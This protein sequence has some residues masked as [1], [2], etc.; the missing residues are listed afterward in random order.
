MQLSAAMTA[1]TLT[2]LDVKMPKTL[3]DAL[4]RTERIITEARTLGVHRD[5]LVPAVIAALSAGKE[6]AVDPEVQR[7]IAAQALGDI[8]PAVQQEMEAELRGFLSQHADE[9]TSCFVA[10]FSAAVTI[11]EVACERL[12]GLALDDS[13]NILALGGDVADVWH[14]ARNAFA[15]VD[16]LTG[17]WRQLG[18]V[19]NQPLNPNHPNGHLAPLTLAQWREHA[20]DNVWQ[21]IQAGIKPDLAP[22][23]TEYARRVRAIAAELASQQQAGLD[24]A[25]GKRDLTT[26]RS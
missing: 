18:M 13:Q 15:Q 3:T 4:T 22:T 8:G 25:L 7:V 2:A 6:P 17:A 9:I 12:G 19:T 1:R 5:A 24:R 21:L 26:L 16:R 10:P 23:Y 14:R 11:L 20:K